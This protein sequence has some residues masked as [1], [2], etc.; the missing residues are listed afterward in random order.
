MR[1]AVRYCR[2]WSS[3][4]YS[5]QR[6]NRNHSRLLAASKFHTGN[7]TLPIRVREDINR[8]R[9]RRLAQKEKRWRPSR[10]EL[11]GSLT[12]LPPLHITPALT[13]PNDTESPSTAPTIKTPSTYSSHGQDY[14]GDDGSSPRSNAT[15]KKPILIRNHTAPMS[16]ANSSRLHSVEG[17]QE[18]VGNIRHSDYRDDGPRTALPSSRHV[19]AQVEVSRPG[20]AGESSRRHKRSRTREKG[21]KDK[22]AMLSK[23]LQKANTAVLLDN[24]QNF[25]GALDAYRDACRLLQHVMDRSYG[26]D[27]KRKFGSH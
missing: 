16:T 2:I 21:E 6:K 14:F 4:T 26:A 1:A 12:A 8:H 18:N 7:Q 23:A 19:E 10:P 25:E 20:T 3:K 5:P 13:D 27:D 11:V 24:A 22:K 17:A 15:G 9:L